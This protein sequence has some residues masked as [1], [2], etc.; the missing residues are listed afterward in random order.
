MGLEISKCYAS[1]S[2]HRISAKLYH[3]YED[4]AYLGGIQMV[5]FHGNRPTFKNFVAFKIGV[6]A[7][8]LKHSIS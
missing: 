1:S 8:I 2:F 7:K 3:V 6:D 5:T 4:T